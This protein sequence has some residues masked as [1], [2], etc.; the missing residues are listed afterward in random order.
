MAEQ[1]NSKPIEELTPD[2]CIDFA[3][4]LLNGEERAEVLR[5]A[6]ASPE[7]E[8]LLRAVMAQAETARSAAAGRTLEQEQGA[9]AEERSPSRK[10]FR[11]G[12]TD[13]IRS[14]LDS[15]FGAGRL[16]PAMAG[17][18]LLILGLII[19]AGT[20]QFFG[21]DDTDFGTPARLI[22]LFPSATRTAGPGAS[23]SSGTG[24][25]L[26]FND[27]EFPCQNPLLFELSGPSGLMLLQGRLHCQPETGEWAG[28]FLPDTL[29]TTG[30]RYRLSLR[31][32]PGEGSPGSE[33]LDF[34]FDVR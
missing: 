3:A 23:V 25:Y 29:L 24:L 16:V 30:G 15:L 5:R 26:E 8:E 17:A 14:F 20:M 1:R 7:S 31:P 34:C 33:P 27:I 19:G 18:S 4:G 2:Q 6:A 32:I 28:L 11:S 12:T 21:P 10:P 13:G 22:S 9:A